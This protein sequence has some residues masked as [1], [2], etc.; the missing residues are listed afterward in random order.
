MDG[1]LDLFIA[2]CPVTAMVQAVS[3]RALADTTLDHLFEANAEGQYTRD[4]T[5][6]TLTRLMTPV[7]FGTYGSVHAAFRKLEYEIPVSITSVYN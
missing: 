6:S 2:A 1:I 4:L 5:F 3:R 7:V